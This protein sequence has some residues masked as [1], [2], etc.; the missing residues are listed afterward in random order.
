VAQVVGLAPLP[1]DLLVDLGVVDH[2]LLVGG[3]G[4]QEH[5]QVVPL[6]GGHLGGGAGVALADRD[7]VDDH[8]RVVL[9]SPLLAEHAVEPLVVARHEV[10]PLADLERLLLRTTRDGEDQR[11]GGDRAGGLHELAPRD[12]P[13]APGHNSSSLGEPCARMTNRRQ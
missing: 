3:G 10:A 11:A 1:L 5:E 12:A 7:V 9:G 13:A 2:L 8:L 4:R 6:L